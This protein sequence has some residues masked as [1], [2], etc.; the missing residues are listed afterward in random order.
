[1]QGMKYL[2]NTKIGLQDIGI[3]VA[4]IALFV[5]TLMPYAQTFAVDDFNIIPESEKTQGEL[6]NDVDC[7]AWTAAGK[8]CKKGTVRDRYN[9]QANSGY[10]ND[11]GAQFATGTFSWNGIMWY[12]VLVIRLIS[13]LALIVWACMIVFAGYKYATAVFYGKAPNTTDTIKNAIIG[14]LIVIFSYAIMRILQSA[15]L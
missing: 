5:W 8:D 11:L 12:L 13:Q 6:G 4:G 14:V 3:G 7:I 15:F 1:M 10:K 2:K 9:N